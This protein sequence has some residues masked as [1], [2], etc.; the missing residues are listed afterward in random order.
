M[1]R[2]NFIYAV[3]RFS[4]EGYI[5]MHVLRILGGINTQ[6]TFY[7]GIMKTLDAIFSA[8]AIHVVGV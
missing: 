8:L 6:T 3:I 7:F 4:S 1:S 2:S 5:A